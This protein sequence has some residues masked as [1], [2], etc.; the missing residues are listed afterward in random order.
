MKRLRQKG[1]KV[2]NTLL[3]PAM[4]AGAIA[5]S[6]KKVNADTQKTL[7]FKV[8]NTIYKESKLINDKLRTTLNYD[9]FSFRLDKNEGRQ[10]QY[11]FNLKAIDNDKTQL[12]VFHQGDIKNKDNSAAYCFGGVLIQ[13]LGKLPILGETKAKLLHLSSLKK[14]DG[15]FH[16]EVVNLMGENI[17]LL[18]QLKTCRDGKTDPQYYVAFHNKDIHASIGKTDGNKIQGVFAT[19]DKPNLSLMS[20]GSYDLDNKVFSLS[21]W[22]AFKNGD[23][24][25]YNQDIARLTSNLMTLGVVEVLF[26]HFDSYLTQG[27]VTHKFDM[28]I[29]KGNF[30]MANQVGLKILPNLGVGGGVLVEKY[31]GKD[32][33]FKPIAEAFYKIPLGKNT[34]LHIEGGYLDGDFT[35]YASL[36]YKK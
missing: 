32:L 34:A 20:W 15:A 3:M 31:R 27:D 22:N 12:S 26:P 25:I 36:H 4:L 13:D 1:K 23:P 18:Y 6:P 11:N 7:D 29:G 5:L 21:A 2:L 14:D 9:N 8:E 17:D 33:K 10:S 35:A 16:K 24:N 30:D 28:N 19:K